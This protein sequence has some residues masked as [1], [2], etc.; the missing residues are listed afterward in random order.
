MKT[1]GILKTAPFLLVPFFVQHSPNGSLNAQPSKPAMPSKPF[2]PKN[3][4]NL[5]NDVT[6]LF[7]LPPLTD[8]EKKALDDMENFLTKYTGNGKLNFGTIDRLIE[9]LV[10]DYDAIHEEGQKMRG[11]KRF[12]IR[13]YP[14]NL[15]NLVYNRIQNEVANRAY[16]ELSTKLLNM[17]VDPNTALN[18]D[19]SPIAHYVTKREL[20]K[21]ENNMPVFEAMEKKYLP[22]N[23]KLVFREGISI[24]AIRYVR[25]RSLGV[26]P[27]AKIVD[28]K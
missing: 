27:G 13:R 15:S 20:D 5:F 19:N 17:G 23:K 21:L 12:F 14:N 2:S 4:D 7:K 28:R 11:P 25:S 3:L 16:A 22:P 10:H 1:P 6:N 18:R 9:G 8:K 24:E 26:P